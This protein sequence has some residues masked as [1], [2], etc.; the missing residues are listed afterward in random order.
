MFRAGFGPFAR[1]LQWVRIRSIKR[2]S[3]LLMKSTQSFMCLA[4][5]LFGACTL[6]LPAAS[7]QVR[8]R[9]PAATGGSAEPFGVTAETS[10]Q[11]YGVLC[12]LDVAGFEEDP[13]T[14]AAV[15]A[16]AA[17]REKLRQMNTPTAQALRQFYKDHALADAGETLAR[18]VSFALVVG[19]P[20]RFSFLLDSDS[21]PPDALSLDGFQELLVRFYSEAHLDREWSLIEPEYDREL[22]RYQGP[23]RLIV[24]VTSGYLR[25]IVRP[26]GNRTFTVFVEPVVGGRIN[27]REYGDHFAIVVG[28]RNDLPIAD[29]RHAYLHFLLD[30][31]VV[32]HA[33][34]VFAKRSLLNIAARAPR[35]P[36]TYRDDFLALMD[37]CLIHAVELR[38]DRVTPEKL[39]AALAQSDA[40]GFILVRPLV[41]QLKIFEKAA[42]SMTLYFPDL[43]RGIDSQAE[44]QRLQKVAF[45]PADSGAPRRTEPGLGGRPVQEVD[46]WLAQ[47]EQ[48][49]GQND[50]L[51]AAATFEKILVKY[52]DEARALYG[53]AIAA[54]Y[55]KQ[56]PL[57]EKLF[58]R[59]VGVDEAGQVRGPAAHDPIILAW[60]HV[61]LGR[62]YDL[63]EER[64][65]ALTEY[66]AALAVGGAPD[67]AQA[68]AQK[69]IQSA[70]RLPSLGGRPE[71]QQP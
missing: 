41:Q 54:V 62:I 3:A 15:P 70:Y 60:S 1:H 55:L 36:V 28:A 56:G 7:A 30:P 8:P 39:E 19:P 29:L 37:E 63:Q 35:L 49:L 34:L 65:R 23:L 22:A 57:A 16:R 67:V 50:A 71:S 59:L 20:P 44:Q 61:Y 17:L 47:A 68:A 11:L 31:L 24:N 12:A 38:L 46:R 9:S 21:L 42:P 26:S 48:Q 10:P 52:P 18:Y 43:L 40:D 58:E 66:R 64:D 4:G 53:R 25:E 51:A 69:G 33:A 14:M 45:A 13:A 5:F 32:Q 27:F 2:Q 6:G